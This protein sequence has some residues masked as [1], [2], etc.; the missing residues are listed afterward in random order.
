M[1]VLQLFILQTACRLCNWQKF[2][3]RIVDIRQQILNH[4]KNEFFQKTAWL[5]ALCL[6]LLS[7]EAQ[8]KKTPVA[9]A[10]TVAATVKTPPVKVASVEGITEYKLSNGLRVLLFPDPSKPTITVN[11][12]Y[13]V[14]AATRD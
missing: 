14:G 4:R 10:K 13:L 6:P 7:I 8:T 3:A 11:I 9:R 12:T 2:I 5:A 1:Y